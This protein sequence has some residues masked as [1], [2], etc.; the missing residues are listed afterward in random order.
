MVLHLARVASLPADAVRGL[1]A[2]L[3]PRVGVPGCDQAHVV[4]VGQPGP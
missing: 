2:L 3:R 4:Q 1:P